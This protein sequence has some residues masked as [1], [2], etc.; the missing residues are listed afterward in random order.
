M[1]LK[2]TFAGADFVKEMRS[3]FILFNLS[4]S[5]EILRENVHQKYFAWTWILLFVIFVCIEFYF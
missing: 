4:I 1:R 3:L 5:V 2:M